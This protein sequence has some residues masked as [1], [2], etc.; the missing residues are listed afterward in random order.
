MVPLTGK[1]A[2]YGIFGDPVAH[3]LSPVM[4]NAAFVEC[5][6]DAVYVP[7]HIHPDH[8]AAAVAS[9]RALDIRGVNVTIPH[10]ETILP[11]LDDI[12][13]DA[14]RIGAVNTIANR[15]G[16]LVGYNTDCSGFLRSARDDLGL[17]AE[18]QQALILG[19]GGAARAAVHA[20]LSTGIE[21]VTVANRSLARAR[22]L[23]TTMSFDP[24]RQL[25]SPV[26]YG[27]SGFFQALSGADLI[28]NTTSVGLSGER[29]DFLPLE[30][31]KGSALIFDMIYSEAGTALTKAA[32]ERGLS[33]V[34]GLSLLAS[35]GEDAFFIWTE[36]RLPPGSMRRF[37]TQ[38]Q[39]SD[40]SMGKG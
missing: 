35:Q 39:Q 17:N 32:A 15:S 10:K 21:Q 33:W 26:A 36:K 13:P 23:A 31:I 14:A 4:Q 9:L 6:I 22:K 3:S 1:T 29:L 20:L 2:V 30:N 34:D 19:A 38:Y 11:L 18:H 25:L 7:F 28:V 40:K 27:T 16:H 24:Q 37:L 8:L 5:C 12:D